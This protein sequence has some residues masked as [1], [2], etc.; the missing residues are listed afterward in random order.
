MAVEECAQ[1]SLRRLLAYADAR[2]P[3]PDDLLH[4]DKPNSKDNYDHNC[5]RSTTLYRFE[6]LFSLLPRMAVRSIK[7]RV[8][9]KRSSNYTQDRRTC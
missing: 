5:K 2:R 7:G 4:S 9:Q 1:D 3:L 8:P 6:T